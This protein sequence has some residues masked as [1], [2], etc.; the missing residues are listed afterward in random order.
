MDNEWGGDEQEASTAHFII[1]AAKFKPMKGHLQCDVGERGRLA[2]FA[3]IVDAGPVV[4]VRGGTG[5]GVHS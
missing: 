1:V 3:A 5:K 4:K 2:T